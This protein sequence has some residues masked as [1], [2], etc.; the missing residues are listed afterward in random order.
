MSSKERTKSRVYSGS[1][2]CEK[3]P[4]TVTGR[5]AVKSLLG[6]SILALVLTLAVRAHAGDSAALSH[7]KS[8]A[9][10]PL[11][12]S[13]VQSLIG[14]AS[15]SVPAGAT[16][17]ACYADPTI[18]YMICMSGNEDLDKAG[19][20]AGHPDCPDTDSCSTHATAKVYL[21]LGAR[22]LGYAWY[23]TAQH[24][25]NAENGSFFPSTP[26]KAAWFE[27]YLP[28]PCTTTPSSTLCT[29]RFR[30]WA[31]DRK[32]SAKFE[33]HWLGPLAGKASSVKAEKPDKP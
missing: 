5:D 17:P 26:G 14:A 3:V 33:V 15:K 18:T 29:D 13:A 23:T 22:V 6:I 32:R 24:D 2:N 28:D 1:R 11:T 7:T 27:V 30:N 9:P 8:T 25:W 31:T 21:P 12:A 10:K 19:K 4:H 16:Q 20:L